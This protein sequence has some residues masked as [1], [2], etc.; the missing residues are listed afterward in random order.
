MGPGTAERLLNSPHLA[1]LPE[2]VIGAG[3][4]SRRTAAGVVGSLT[5]R[6]LRAFAYQDDEPGEAMARALAALADP[7]PLRV[8]D[9]R[10]SRLTRHGVGRVAGAGLAAGLEQLDIGDNHVG[11]DGFLE[12]GRGALPA[13]RRLDIMRTGPGLEG[14]EH[15]LPAP[16]TRHLWSLNLGG[17]A[18]GAPAGSMLG[19]MLP[20]VRVLDLRDNRLGDAGATY[21]AR[22]RFDRLLHLDLSENGV[23]AAGAAA[24]LDAPWLDGVIALDLGG[25][26]LP[27]DA[28]ARLRDRLGER[29]LV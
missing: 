17:N 4:T 21:L 7:P 29:A 6:G 13:L 2:L 20:E 28:K 3:L 15:L 25:N 14:L 18:L 12:L 16:V 27:A 19:V 5:F 26:P 11:P 9:L 10:S 8:L 22:F 1:G 24:L 23:T